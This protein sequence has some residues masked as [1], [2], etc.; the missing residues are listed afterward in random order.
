MT[1][2][3]FYKTV[4]GKSQKLDER[5]PE[6]K[7]RRARLWLRRLQRAFDILNCSETHFNWRWS[8]QLSAAELSDARRCRADVDEWLNAML[9]IHEKQQYYRTM[10]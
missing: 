4:F 9:I 6:T 10:L 3:S 1:T 8:K 2:P 5:T 7:L